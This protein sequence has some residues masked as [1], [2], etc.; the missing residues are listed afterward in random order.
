MSD[1]SQMTP[2]ELAVAG[3]P[4]EVALRARITE[5]WQWLAVHPDADPDVRKFEIGRSQGLRDALAIIEA[6]R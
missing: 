1:L 3:I 4:V 5:Q 6:K 2:A